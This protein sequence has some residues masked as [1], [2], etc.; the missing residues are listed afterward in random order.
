MKKFTLKAFRAAIKAL[1]KTEVWHLAAIKLGHTPTQ[2]ELEKLIDKSATSQKML[3]SKWGLVD[4]SSERY[5]FRR[6]AETEAFIRRGGYRQFGNKHFKTVALECLRDLLTKPVSSYTKV[7]MRGHTH[8]Y[9]C[10]PVYGHH[11]YNKV[12]TCELNG[13]EAFVTQILN[14]ANRFLVNRGYIV[15]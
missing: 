1:D 4:H 14:L 10:S 12:M 8:L 7:P 11:D 15:G 13:N 2:F 9:F 5:A 6:K 3:K